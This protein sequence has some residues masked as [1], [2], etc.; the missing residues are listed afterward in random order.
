MGKTIK[1]EAETVR[2]LG[3]GARGVR[4]VNINAPDYVIGLD[5]V[6]MDENEKIAQADTLK[7]A[8]AETPAGNVVDNGIGTEDLADDEES[9]GS[10]PPSENSENDE[11]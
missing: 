2:I 9:E 5:K 3:K 7:D 4:I 8:L 11:V 6:V 1:I 10:V